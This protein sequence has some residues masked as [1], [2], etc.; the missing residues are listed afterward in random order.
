[1]VET[2]NILNY[3]KEIEKKVKILDYFINY[4]KE[5]QHLIKINESMPD[6]FI[7]IKDYT[8]SKYAVLFVLNNDVYQVIFKDSLE[9]HIIK[10]DHN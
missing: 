2:Y 5:N 3:P 7:F 10:E 4:L 9:I 6:N 8:I 1:M